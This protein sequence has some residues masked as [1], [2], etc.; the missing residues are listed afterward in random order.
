MN[1]ITQ[2]I[3]HLG[4]GLQILDRY[5]GMESRRILQTLRSA[6]PVTRQL[7]PQRRRCPK[8]AN[9]SHDPKAFACLGLTNRFTGTFDGI[10]GDE[11]RYKPLF[12]SK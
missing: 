10:S 6:D 11:H 9:F 12:L 4:Y 3:Q 2:P 1:I 5:K 7:H 8:D